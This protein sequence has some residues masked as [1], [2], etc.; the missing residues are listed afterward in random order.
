[1]RSGTRTCSGRCAVRARRASASSPGSCCG[2]FPPASRR[3]CTSSCPR[4]RRGGSRLAG[5]GAR[6]RGRARREPADRGRR[7]ASVRRLPRA[8]CRCRR[9]SS[10]ASAAASLEELP[11]ARSSAGWPRP[12]RATARTCR[13]IAPASSPAPEMLASV[14]DAAGA[15]STSRRWAAP[16]TASADA[17]AFAHR[18]ARFCLRWPAAI[19]RGSSRRSRA[20]TGPAASTRTSRSPTAIAGTRRITSATATG[21]WDCASDTTRG[22]VLVLALAMTDYERATTSTTLGSLPEPIRGAVVTKAESLQLTVADDA[23]AFLTHSR[24]AEANRDA[25]AACSAATPTEST[26]PRS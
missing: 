8:A 5:V 1:M 17:T 22:G 25:G 26:T 13:S 19:P 15:S 14:G 3:R 7:R 12:A 2:R 10:S 9:S 18:D 16:T 23:Q 20:S 4:A 6:R 24:Q 11:T 21:C